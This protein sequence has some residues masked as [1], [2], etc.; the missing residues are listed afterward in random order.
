MMIDTIKLIR[1]SILAE[2]ISFQEYIHCNPEL[3][4]CEENTA[5]FVNYIL[6]REGIITY[7]NYAPNSVVAVVEGCLPTAKKPACVALRADMDALPITES[8]N[9]A[10]RSQKEGIMHACGHDIH[11][12]SLLGTALILKKLENNFSGKVVFIFQPAEEKLPGGAKTM[13]DNGLLRD[14][15][16]ML[17]LGQ[18]VLPGLPVGSFGFCKGEYMASTDEIYIRFSGRGGH[19]ATPDITSNTVMALAEFVMSTQTIKQ[20]SA[21]TSKPFVLSFG[22]LNADGAT[23]IIPNEARAEGTFR[24]FDEL[25][26]AEVKRKLHILANEIA[27]RYKCEAHLKIVDG[28]PFVLN[29]PEFTDYCMQIAADFSGADRVVRL[30]PRLTAEDFGYFSHEIPAVF[31]RMGIAADGKGVTNLHNPDFDHSPAA[32]KDAPAMMAWLAMKLVNDFPAK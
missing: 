16:P 25:F 2:T 24:C 12:A 4:F 5:K 17:I 18:H 14:F 31:Y 27:P 30:E 7:R 9:H 8:L 29:N 26:R 15:A 10:P 19:A 21:K 11:T 6:N 20:K 23:N 28:Y 3:S 1:D 22:R 32:L 13:I